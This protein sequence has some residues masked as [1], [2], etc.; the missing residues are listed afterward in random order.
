MKFKNIL[1]SILLESK[2]SEKVIQ[3]LKNLGVNDYNSEALGNIAGSIYRLLAFRI[4]EKY[5][6][7]AGYEIPKDVKERF[8]LV[9]G[10][11]AFVWRRIL[12]GKFR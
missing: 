2:M 4:L 1:E 11:N 3:K 12:L 10:S 9:N 5:E 8:A 6:Q 7:E